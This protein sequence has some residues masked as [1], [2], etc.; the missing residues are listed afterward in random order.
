MTSYQT[1]AKLT[2]PLVKHFS[3][4]PK[5]PSSGSTILYFP[6]QQNF[7]K[8]LSTL[9]QRIVLTLALPSLTLH[10]GFCLAHAHQNVKWL[11]PIVSTCSHGSHWFLNVYETSCQVGATPSFW[12]RSVSRLEPSFMKHLVLVM[13]RT[14]WK[15]STR[16]SPIG[17]L[18]TSQK[19]VLQKQPWRREGSKEGVWSIC[20]AQGKRKR[21]NSAP[22]SRRSPE[23]SRQNTGRRSCDS[24]HL[25]WSSRGR[26]WGAATASLWG[27]QQCMWRTQSSPHLNVN[28]Y[29]LNWERRGLI[30]MNKALS[31]F[32]WL[33]TQW[34][35]Q[36]QTVDIFT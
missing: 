21:L 34:Y 11:V 22:H 4:V 26:P 24:G 19:Q 20:P 31:G 2:Q 32:I 15:K 18:C 33:G 35:L 28:I 1:V 12:A 16:L 17:K 29:F 25:Y 30:P 27:V 5:I 3:L 23:E 13:G 7:L 10:W 9:P 8:E 6:S 36:E 14:D